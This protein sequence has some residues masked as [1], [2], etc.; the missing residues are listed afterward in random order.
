MPADLGVDDAIDSIW[1]NLWW[2]K[3]GLI[4][5]IETLLDAALRST[6]NPFGSVALLDT[7]VSSGNVP[8]LDGT[9]KI[10]SSI[11]PTNIPASSFSGTFAASLIPGLP[12]SK[13]HLATP[14]VSPNIDRIRTDQIPTGLPA[15][16]FTS[17]TVDPRL[18][19]QANVP[20]R[21]ITGIPDV[22]TFTYDDSGDRTHM[23]GPALPAGLAAG[24]NS[25]T[26][27]N[28][29]GYDSSTGTLTV[30]PT[31]IHLEPGS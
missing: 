3:V 30:N 5:R 11:I 22:R 2:T 1:T 15:S 16:V 13:M 6:L 21:N 28:P 18:L 9:G 10:V 27:A 26:P 19:P 7:G 4:D 23:Q 14:Q 31:V 17:G 25:W 29:G 8:L 20:I 24:A 12:M